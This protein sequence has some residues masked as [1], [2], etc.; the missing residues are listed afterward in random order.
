MSAWNFSQK[1]LSENKIFYSKV[2]RIMA[3]KNQMKSIK[4]EFRNILNKTMFVQKIFEH[5]F[6]DEVA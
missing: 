4:H 2:E 5:C 1:I 6:L 3:Q